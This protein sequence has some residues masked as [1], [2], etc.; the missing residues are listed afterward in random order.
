LA[1]Q[2]P[3]VLWLAITFCDLLKIAVT[4]LVALEVTAM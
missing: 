3:L 4:A 1:T 2:A